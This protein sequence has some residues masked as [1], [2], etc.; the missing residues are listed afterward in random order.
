MIQ[1]EMHITMPQG[2]QFREVD[3]QRCPYFV[4]TLFCFCDGILASFIQSNV[5]ILTWLVLERKSSY[6]PNEGETQKEDWFERNILQLVKFGIGS[7]YFSPLPLWKKKTK[8]KQK[9]NL[10]KVLKDELT[11]NE[12]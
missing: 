1:K 9:G 6:H 11:W 12:F 5:D 3:K 4:S 2:E 8:Q 10:D 7:S